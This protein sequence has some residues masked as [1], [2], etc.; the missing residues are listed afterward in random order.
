MKALIP[1]V[2]QVLAAT[3][4]AD[5]LASIAA[6]ESEKRHRGKGTSIQTKKDNISVILAG[7]N[8]QTAIQIHDKMPSMNIRHLRT[9]LYEMERDGILRKTGGRGNL[10]YWGVEM[11]CHG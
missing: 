4:Y 11:K 7:K 8:G 1:M 6:E 3:R 2:E 5:Y 10:R 9:A